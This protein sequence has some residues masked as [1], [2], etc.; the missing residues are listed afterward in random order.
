M[1]TLRCPSYRGTILVECPRQS[2]AR[3]NCQ[4]DGKISD[5]LSDVLCRLSNIL[6]FVLA[7]SV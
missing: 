1:Y 4:L 5:I 3:R 7:T 6:A 2:E